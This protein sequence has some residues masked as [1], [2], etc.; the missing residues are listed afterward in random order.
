MRRQRRKPHD[1]RHTSSSSPEDPD[2][3]SSDVVSQQVNLAMRARTTE[4][5]QRAGAL[6]GALTELT[7]A[8][9]STSV[10]RSAHPSRAAAVSVEH[11]TSFKA[12]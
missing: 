11:G 9:T 8:V 7:Q 5:E 12:P 3:L 4:L 10:T 1:P 6:K 2:L